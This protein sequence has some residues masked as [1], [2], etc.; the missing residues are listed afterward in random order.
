MEQGRKRAKFPIP[1]DAHIY[2]N[3]QEVYSATLRVE[4]ENY[5]AYRM[6]N[7]LWLIYLEEYDSIYEPYGFALEQKG[8]IVADAQNGGWVGTFEAVV[9][10]L[11]RFI[12]DRMNQLW[13][14]LVVDDPEILDLKHPPC[15]FDNVNGRTVE[16][17]GSCIDSTTF[18]MAHK[19]NDLEGMLARILAN[20]V[21]ILTYLGD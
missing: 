17:I 20:Q 1:S 21:T 2:F 15:T 13:H 4:G 19:L 5:Y 12:Q 18:L 10:E 6:N 3:S 16:S 11:E 9:D 14:E 7:G 8:K